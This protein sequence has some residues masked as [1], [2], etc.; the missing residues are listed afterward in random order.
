MDSQWDA[1]WTQQSTKVLPERYKKE[2][3]KK[4]P[5]ETAQRLQNELQTESQT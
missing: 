3:L 4:M 1:K 5:T 2:V